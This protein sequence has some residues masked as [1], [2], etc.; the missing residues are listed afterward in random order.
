MTSK[1]KGGG[2]ENIVG[3]IGDYFFL[4]RTIIMKRKKIGK[5]EGIK[6]TVRERE[7][8][9]LT[10]T[11]LE[12]PPFHSPLIETQLTFVLRLPLSQTFFLLVVVT[13]SYNS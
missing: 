8:E 7:K 4:E 9:E 13:S 3:V 10:M 1:L 5:V 12:E 11:S 6:S 2:L